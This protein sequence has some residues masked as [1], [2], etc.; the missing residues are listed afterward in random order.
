M[1]RCLR[2]KG[3]NGR[4]VFFRRHTLS[5]FCKLHHLQ[6]LPALDQHTYSSTNIIFVFTLHICNGEDS[7]GGKLDL[8]KGIFDILPMSKLKGHIILFCFDILTCLHGNV[9]YISHAKNTYQGKLMFWEIEI[10]AHYFVFETDSK[11]LF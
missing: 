5:Q 6:V 4:H 7:E 1:A 10:L 2:Q 9:N 11:M 8:R 3:C